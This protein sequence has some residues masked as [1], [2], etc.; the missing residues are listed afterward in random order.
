MAAADQPL[1]ERM[2][3]FWHGHF[4]TSSH[5]V[6]SAFLMYTQNA[7]LRT[8]AL[9]SFTT[10]ARSMVVDP[11]MLIWLD[12]NDNTA[13]APNENLSREFM[14]LFTLGA[15]HYGEPDVKEAARAL[16]GWVVD[17]ETGRARFARR[18]HDDAPA[19]LLGSTAG[20]DA[21][22]FVDLV[23]AQPASAAFVV[24]RVWFRLVSA[25]ALTDAS[26]ERLV[27]AYGDRRGRPPRCSGRWPA[28]R[29]SATRRARWSSP[30]VEW[31]TGLLRAL[32]VRLADLP[33]K[34]A[35]ADIDGAARH[36]PDP[37]RPTQRRGLAGRRGVADYRRCVLPVRDRPGGRGGGA[38]AQ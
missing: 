20:L 28:S 1:L 5:K 38:A 37:L 32:G 6:R 33:P 34:T 15:G 30:P 14:E 31:L 22:G 3:W 11:A 7:T 17:R 13:Q 12:G 26:R 10:L 19:T 8:A 9:G 24:D 25:T 36:G 18:R 23:L 29:R 16:T 4:A 2:T 21:P 27:A 35:H